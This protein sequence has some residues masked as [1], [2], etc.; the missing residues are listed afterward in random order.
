MTAPSGTL[1]GLVLLTAT[2]ALVLTLVISPLVVAAFRRR[3]TVSMNAASPGAAPVEP[4]S[5][6]D[7][8][9]GSAGPEHPLIAVDTAVDLA[10]AAASEDLLALARRKLRRIAMAY[11]SGGLVHAAVCSAFF[12]VSF[13]PEY[14]HSRP[15]TGRSSS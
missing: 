3:V 12:L 1:E 11:A 5:A 15:F 13:G 14:V 6:G 10:P 4:S 2:F 8:T 9:R 7:L